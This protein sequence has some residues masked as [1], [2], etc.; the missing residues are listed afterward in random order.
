MS[1]RIKS[2]ASKSW[3]WY[4]FFVAMSIWAL[5]EVLAY[6]FGGVSSY[7]ASRLWVGIGIFYV[8]ISLWAVACA[9][10]SDF[11]SGNFVN[12]LALTAVIAI[13]CLD[14]NLPYVDHES[15]Q[16]ATDAR[17]N[18]AEMDLGYTRT[19]FLGYPSRQ[20]LWSYLPTYIF[21]P[22]FVAL[23]WGYAWPFLLG[24][25]LFYAGVQRVSTKISANNTLPAL[26][27]LSIPCFPYVYEF[28]LHF[29]Q[30]ILPISFVLQVVG[31]GLLA[32]TTFSLPNLVAMAWIGSMLGT[33]YTPSLSCWAILIALLTLEVVRLVRLKQPRHA[34]AWLATA[35]VIV[36]LGACSFYTRTDLSS[37]L[38]SGNLTLTR[39]QHNL[40]QILDLLLFPKEKS[41]FGTAMILPALLY[42]LSSILFRHGLFHFVLSLGSVGIILMSV[43]L[44]GYADPPPFL[45]LHRAMV[46]I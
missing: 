42:L 24:L 39:A 38:D 11:R 45:A 17:N 19:A 46:A 35:L 25:M 33:S 21:G 13:F 10:Y 32:V 8:G 30:V 41:F 29:E 12:I 27:L 9:V 43:I 1:E 37:S 18:L 40:S 31:W 5:V 14:V 22:S 4:L 6:Q 3:V 34:A 23:R 2:P 36:S 15:T 20:Y 7:L 28:F 26:A 44:R 16:Q